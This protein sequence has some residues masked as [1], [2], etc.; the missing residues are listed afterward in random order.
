MF[1][2]PNIIYLPPN[3]KPWYGLNIQSVFG[4]TLVSLV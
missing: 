1:I 4:R 3:V 2:D